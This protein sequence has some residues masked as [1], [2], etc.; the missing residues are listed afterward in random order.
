MPME[1]VAALIAT[2]FFEN[3]DSTLP[4][5]TSM[6]DSAPWLLGPNSIVVCERRRNAS[7]PRTITAWL[8][9]AVATL[10]PSF[11]GVPRP[12]S[13]PFTVSDP[14]SFATPGGRSPFASAC[15]MIPLAPAAPNA[16]MR[17][18]HSHL[19][20][21]HLSLF[22]PTAYRLPLTAYCLPPREN[23]V[24][25]SMA[26]LDPALFELRLRPRGRSERESFHGV[27]QPRRRGEYRE[28]MIR[29]LLPIRRHVQP[30][31]RREA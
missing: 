3:T 19:F 15:E 1:A 11:T 26:Q 18:N 6:S 22:S 25:H 30:A 7:D 27:R 8:P 21:F 9:R 5:L 16:A 17:F 12:A 20:T 10:S 4:A 29:I 28:H 13:R 23:D 24:P 14:S 31:A 2:G